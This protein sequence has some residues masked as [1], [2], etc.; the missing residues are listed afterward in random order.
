MQRWKR[1]RLHLLNHLMD[2]L[3]PALW[4]LPLLLAPLLPLIV[5]PKLSQPLMITLPFPMLQPFPPFSLLLMLSLVV[6]LLL[7]HLAMP[8]SMSMLPRLLY[9]G[10]EDIK[11]AI[12]L[13]PAG[14]SRRGSKHISISLRCRV[15]RRYGFRSRK[16]Y[17]ISNISRSTR[18]PRSRYDLFSTD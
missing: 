15:L 14:H 12:Y 18:S 13:D 1:H 11:L 6:V 7:G 5:V 10:P 16:L 2:V 4:T 9:L 17:T 3:G 8:M